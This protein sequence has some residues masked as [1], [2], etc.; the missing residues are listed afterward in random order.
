MTVMPARVG[1]Y[2]RVREHMSESKTIIPARVGR[3]VDY[4]PF[5]GAAD[6]ERDV[7]AAIICAVFNDDEVNLVWFDVDGTPNKAL[8]VR[9]MQE[10]QALP[11]S[12][13]YCAWMPFQIGQAKAHR[14]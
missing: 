9:L 2:P 7:R 14:S 5:G 8:H 10:G 13:S 6:Q 1:R 11:I 3:H 4:F 12:G